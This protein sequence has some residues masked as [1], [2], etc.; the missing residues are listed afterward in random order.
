MPGAPGRVQRVGLGRPQTR[1]GSRA[2]GTGGSSEA[3][4]PSDLA[5]QQMSGTEGLAFQP[6]SLPGSCGW[7]QGH[8]AS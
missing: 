2:S 7:F 4:G 1:P 3:L 6:P 8:G 5:A